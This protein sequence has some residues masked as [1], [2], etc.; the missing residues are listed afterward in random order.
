MSS[1][2]GQRQES[3]SATVGMVKR[4]TWRL[5]FPVWCIPSSPRTEVL[6]RVQINSQSRSHPSR[7]VSA[8]RSSQETDIRSHSR[9]AFCFTQM[10]RSH[11]QMHSQTVSAP[12]IA[13]EYPDGNGTPCLSSLY[14]VGLTVRAA[15]RS[16]THQG[17]FHAITLAYRALAF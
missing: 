4:P 12:G 17:D 3:L 2:A 5:Q 1:Q 9:L 14:E 10:S 13:L 15:S 8:K 11:S 7:G 16:T 6:Q